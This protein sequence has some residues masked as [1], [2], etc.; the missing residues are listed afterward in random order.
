MDLR[1]IKNPHFLKQLS[2]DELVEL[3]ADIRQFLIES[4]SKTGGHLA[5]NLG[6]VELTIALHKVFDAPKDKIIFDVGHQ[7]YVHKILT[8][9]IQGF[10]SLRQFN[11]MSGYPK[12]SESPYDVFETG[13]SSTSISA[14]AGFVVA[15]KNLNKDGEVIAVIGDGA[16]TGG[17]AFEAINYFGHTDQKMIIVL[18]DNE[19]SISDNVGALSKVLKGIRSSRPYISF[20]NI[21]PKF[22][23]SPIN[24]LT[25]AL[26]Y[27]IEGTNIFETLGYKYYGPVDGHNLPKLMKYLEVAKKETRPVIIHVRTKKGK[28]YEPAEANQEK[29]HGIGYYEVEN[30]KTKE[31]GLSWSVGVSEMVNDVVKDHLTVI[32][33]AMIHGSGLNVFRDRELIDVGIAEG[34]A[35]TM[36]AGIA[37][38]NQYVYLS[39]YSTFAQRAYDQILHDIARTDMHVVFGID[40]AGIVPSDGDTHQ[41]IFDISMFQAMPNIVITQPKDLNEAR[42]LIEYGFYKN[43]HPFVIRFPKGNTYPG[44]KAE[45]IN[46]PSWIQETEG[47]QINIISYGP[48]INRIIKIAVNSDI[49]ANIYNAR[50]INPIDEKMLQEIKENGLPTLVYEE[51]IESGSL[52]QTLKAKYN[53][54]VEMMNLTSIPDHGDRENLLKFYELDDKSILRRIRKLCD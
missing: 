16:M 34:H 10:N 50:F 52:G 42:E 14:A 53:L 24:K 19:M 37:S 6:V 40:R 44:V 21:I 18:N 41:G 49:S 47:D 5:S 15:N 43:R 8:G 29:Y 3:S 4:I 54:N 33:P 36:A 48:N 46:E 20:K 23:K 45:P 12:L 25:N 26:K 30:G 39:L 31:P 17:M 1:D 35:A 11:G 27:T 32:T 22:M 51:V 9:R 38:M 28:G 13:H 7:S 2:N